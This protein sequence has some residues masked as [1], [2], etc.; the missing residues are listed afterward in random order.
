MIFKKQ[1]FI[2]LNKNPIDI[3]I[4][5]I[6]DCISWWDYTRKVNGITERD[7]LVRGQ[8]Y[9]P[10]FNIFGISSRKSK[11]K[12]VFDTVPKINWST[13]SLIS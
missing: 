11:A 10:D 2:L 8:D 1:V 3:N 7:E 5:F 6:V 9:I 12:T 13:I 4:F